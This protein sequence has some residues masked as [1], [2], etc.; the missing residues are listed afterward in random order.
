MITFNIIIKTNPMEFASD[1][2]EAIQMMTR[3]QGRI[4]S[5]EHT[6]T[7]NGQDTLLTYILIYEYD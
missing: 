5:T 2:R 6:A 1:V 3:K 7:F 4:L